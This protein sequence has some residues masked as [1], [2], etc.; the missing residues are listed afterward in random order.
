MLH[1]LVL[2]FKHGLKPLLVTHNPLAT[3]RPCPYCENLGKIRDFMFIP[4][5]IPR[6]ILKRV[7]PA[8]IVA[9]QE[10]ENQLLCI[11]KTTDATGR[12]EAA[13]VKEALDNWGIS[14]DT[15]IA[16]SFD[17]TSSNTGVNSGGA[18]LLQQLLNRQL[19]WLS[20]RHNV[21]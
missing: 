20:C 5:V 18:V 7:G 4:V 1:T 10:M 17:T 16:S 6:D 13:A 21:A 2:M 14:T 15:I 11:T 3:P 8:A 9:V 19:L 12:V